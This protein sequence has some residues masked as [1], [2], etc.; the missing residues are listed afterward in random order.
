MLRVPAS[1]GKVSINGE[2]D[3]VTSGVQM[4][5]MGGQGVA[6]DTAAIPLAQEVAA[7]LSSSSHIGDVLAQ[8]VFQ[9]GFHLGT[10]MLW[11]REDTERS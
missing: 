3:A 9:E 10:V 1:D 7:Y 8:A 5:I 2:P 11:K 4:E 6:A